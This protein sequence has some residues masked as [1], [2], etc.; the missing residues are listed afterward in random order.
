MEL[1]NDER[2]AFTV[3]EID[4]LRMSKYASDQRLVDARLHDVKNRQHII[5]LKSQMCDLTKST[6]QMQ[7]SDLQKEENEL[8]LARER[9]TS[10]YNE[11][12]HSDLKKKYNIPEESSFS[13]NP[14]TCQVTIE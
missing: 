3:E 9:L 14:I 2:Q 4:C 8:K 13:F 6:F 5:Q 12:V 1:A 10:I 7:L 11:T